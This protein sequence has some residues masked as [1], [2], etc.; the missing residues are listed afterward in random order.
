MKNSNGC[1]R[2]FADK[3]QI[4]RCKQNVVDV[5]ASVGTLS[6]ALHLAGNEVRL[7]ILYLL[8]KEGELCVCDMSD[9]L[10]MKA[11]AISQHLR[12]MRD[13]SII[14]FRKDGQTIYYF[15]ETPHHELFESFFLL[16]SDNKILKKVG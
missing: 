14:D 16:I 13:G 12:K 11:P 8:Y 6:K 2:V 1:I 15:L 5:A 4:E 3:K 7:N 9:I 10:N